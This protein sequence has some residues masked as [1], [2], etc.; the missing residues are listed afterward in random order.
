MGKLRNVAKKIIFMSECGKGSIFSFT[1]EREERQRQ[2]EGGRVG[3]RERENVPQP[4]DET[5][6]FA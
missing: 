5:L 1:K 3:G 4:P 2:R 6:K